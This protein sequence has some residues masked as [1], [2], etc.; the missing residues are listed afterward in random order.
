MLSQ[1][2]G[3]CTWTPPSFGGSR[4]TFLKEAVARLYE[5][6]ICVTFA[7][8]TPQHTA[9]ARRKTFAAE[10]KQRRMNAGSVRSERPMS[11]WEPVLAQLAGQAGASLQVPAARRVP[12][13]IALVRPLSGQ[14]MSRSSYSSHA[15]AE[16]APPPPPPRRSSRRPAG[17]P[18]P[19]TLQHPRQLEMADPR[20]PNS[21]D[22]AVFRIVEM[23]FSPEEA[24]EALRAT[25][26][27]D[28]LRVDHAV[29]YLLRRAEGGLAAKAVPQGAADGALYADC[30]PFGPDGDEDEGSVSVRLGEVEPGFDG[31]PLEIGE[32]KPI[33]GRSWLA[34]P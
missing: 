15:S 7:P 3:W 6:K 12:L 17:P 8:E 2:K 24:K 5:E 16:P 9:Q 26:R 14:A 20:A 10:I 27:G 1:Q 21:A 25:D 19:A 23:G 4:S 32:V 28:R 34:D 30:G 18:P 31:E 33:D 29:E 22:R 11:G 13:D